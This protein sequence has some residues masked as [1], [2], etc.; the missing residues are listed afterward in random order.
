M[1]AY[2]KLLKQ[3]ANTS[4]LLCVG[5]DTDLKKIPN[6]LSKNGVAGMLEFNKS[7]IDALSNSVCGFKINFA[8][9][10]QF[11]AEGFECLKQTFDYIPDHSFKIADA[12]RADIGNTSKA[13]AKAIY[14]YFGA[15]SATLMPYMGMDSI[16]PFLDY[17]NKL[18]FLIAL[19]SN[20][21]AKDFQRLQS[22]G[23]PF[24]YHIIQH[25]KKY[26]KPEN[27]GYVVGA[28]YSE[29]LDQIRKITKNRVLLIPG[30]GAQ[31]G[32]LED[33]VDAN[34]GATSIISVSRSI[35]YASN[36]TDFAEK[37]AQTANQLNK[38]IKSFQMA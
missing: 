4:S 30:I 7:I 27:L 3:Q 11:G 14:E 13:Y 24:Y 26:A 36:D 8:F 21:G 1:T 19:S 5:L 16:K 25:S 31:G 37:A 15:D 34:K 35:I 10:E 9:Y 32:S 28:T 18:N 2:E 17:E 22:D 29:E 20:P 23:K 38:Q 12:K 33:T 6:H